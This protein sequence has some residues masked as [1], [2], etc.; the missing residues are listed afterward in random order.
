MERTVERTTEIR[1][2]GY[3]VDFYGHVNNARYLEFI[4]EARWA[5]LGDNVDFGEWMR[6][7]IS[8]FVVNINITYKRPAF[9]GETI[10]IRSG[11]TKFGNKSV[12]LNQK[13][14]LKGTDTLIADADVIFVITD[15]SGKPARIEGAILAMFKPLVA[16]EI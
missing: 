1:I 10:E 7:G 11:I 9:L 12:T 3:H 14:F 8:F 6:K 13:I 15:T 2:R 4:E 16:Q 5:L